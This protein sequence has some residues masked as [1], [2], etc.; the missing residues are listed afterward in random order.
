MNE[1]R[2]FLQK[3]SDFKEKKIEI[4]KDSFGYNQTY[5]YS[6]LDI[7]LE[8]VEP[9]L[10]EVGLWYYHTTG[11]NPVDGRNTLITTIYDVDGTGTLSSSTA[12]KDDVKLAKMNEFMVLGS[13][14]TYFR[15]YHLV[16]MLGLLTD[17]DN[18]ASVGASVGSKSGGR[19]VDKSAPKTD[20]I[21]TFKGLL[22]NGQPK[23]KVEAFYKN[24]EKNFSDENR[25]EIR[26]LIDNHFKSA[27]KDEN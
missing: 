1:K 11:I 25:A 27:S 2:N 22:D 20:Y 26:E 4:P 12:I 23:D 14:I 9:R 6:S 8:K 3:L 7:V 10:R 16:C 24:Y 13:A 17:Q 21:K 5:S 19:S 15:R 18:D